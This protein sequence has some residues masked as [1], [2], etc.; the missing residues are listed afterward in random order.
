[1]VNRAGQ[2]KKIDEKRWRVFLCHYKSTTK[3]KVLNKAQDKYFNI[4]I[5]RGGNVIMS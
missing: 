1:M 2:I 5:N 3:M 4:F